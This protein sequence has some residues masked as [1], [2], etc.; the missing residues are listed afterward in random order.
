MKK[1]KYLI[2]GGGISGISTAVFLGKNE[3]Y[4]IIE[5]EEELGGYCRTVFQDGF[6]WDF[7][8][9]FFHFKNEE[10]KNLIFQN[11]DPNV[12]LQIDKKSSII[13]KNKIINFP[14]QKNI[15]DL[16]KEEFIECLYDFYNRKT[17][18]SP[19]NFLDWV[20]QN[21][22]EGITNKFVKPYNE[23]LYA[24]DLSELDI[25]AMG[26]F[27]PKVTLD[28]IIE[29]LKVKR[30]TSYNNSFYYPKTGAITYVN[31]LLQ[32]VDENKISKGEKITSIDKNSK[33]VKTTKG[34]YEYEYLISSLPLNKLLELSNTEHNS[35]IYSSNK[36][37]VFNLGFDLPS[38]NPFHWIYVPSY[39]TS[40]Y[41]V[42]FYD[43]ILGDDRCSM[44]VEIGL[45]TNQ[46]IDTK[47]YLDTV[48]LDLRRLKL[49]DKHNLI[50]WYSIVMDPAYVHLTSDSMKDS[51]I[52]LEKLENQNIYSI[53]RYGQ[54][55]YCSIEDNIV[56]AKSTVKKIKNDGVQ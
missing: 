41:R 35:K 7:S 31:S 1:V 23:K 14:F 53:G 43:N 29:S 39:E 6:T 3:D 46:E 13:Y 10:I 37:L 8:G 11:I 22:G 12:V 55:T 27:F 44:Y 16:E 50:S 26:R 2:L 25:N 48:L 45:K 51:Q 47:T 15:G 49:I 18:Y 34:V 28:E 33:L 20:Y 56:S 24:C 32:N 30:D 40:F 38:N 17:D 4:L 5:K 52:Q 21:L 54:W 36:V 9:H 42:G 19:N